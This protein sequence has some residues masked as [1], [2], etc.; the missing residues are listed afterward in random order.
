MVALAP[1][2]RPTLP[3][4]LLPT[5]SVSRLVSTVVHADNRAFRH[6]SAADDN[7]KAEG[8]CPPLANLTLGGAPAPHLFD[9]RFPLW[10]RRF[11][12]S[13]AL[14]QVVEPPELWHP[15]PARVPSYRSLMRHVLM[16][17]RAEC[18]LSLYE[19]HRGFRVL[20]SFAQLCVRR[21]RE[22]APIEGCRRRLKIASKVLRE[23]SPSSLARV[24]TGW[25]RTHQWG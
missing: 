11:P 4:R 20:D 10:Y 13:Q 7:R 21:C 9:Q 16:R 23:S 17:T 5:L 19:R 12:W 3:A 2:P 15:P 1:P 25:H 18:D 8:N 24:S 14:E 22:I 6:I